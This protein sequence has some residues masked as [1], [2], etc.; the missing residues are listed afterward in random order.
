MNKEKYSHVKSRKH[1]GAFYTPSILSDFLS[2]EIINRIDNFEQKIVITDPAIGDGELI[3]SLLEK[4]PKNKKIIVYGFDINKESIKISKERISSLFKN[5]ELNIIQANFLNYCLSEKQLIK[6]DIV[7]ANPPYIRNQKLGTELSK[8]L[9]VDFKIKGRIDIYQAFIIGINN[10]LS[11]TGVAGVIMS[12]RFLTT[13]GAGEF[14]DKIYNLYD[15]YELLDLGNTKIFDAAV[16]PA[17]MLFSLKNNNEKPITKFKSIYE[18]NQDITDNDILFETPLAA[19]NC[20]GIIKCKTGIKYTIKNGI[21]EFDGN[22]KNIWR[23]HDSESEEWLKKVEVNTW[24]RFGDIGKIRVGVK[25]TADNVFIRDSFEGISDEKIIKPLIT[26]HVAGRF[27][28]LPIKTKEILYTH[29]F[30]GNKKT[31]INLDEYPKAKSYLEKNKQQLDS[32]NYIH[33]SNRKWYEIWVPQNP[34]LWKEEKIIFRDICERPT[35]WFNNEDSVVNGDCY[36]LINDYKKD[37]NEI[38]WLVLAVANSTF[39]EKFYD[40]K[41]NNKLY[42]NKRR[43]ISQYV[44]NFPLPNPNTLMSKNMIDLSKKIYHSK[45]YNIVEYEKKLDSLVWKSFGF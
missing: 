26:H 38:L 33:Q 18:T 32:R 6:S 4:I 35:F 30:V 29:E 11:K 21:L 20:K 41:F 27:K 2:S 3:I 12:N 23:I 36:W 44:E 14:R 13:K 39:I 1:D 17:I 19:L 42:S 15:I 25:T 16:L 9:S 43:F 22:P 37:Y 45:I 10:I 7:I 28:Q 40:I 5:V 24:A 31:V 8:K 34:S